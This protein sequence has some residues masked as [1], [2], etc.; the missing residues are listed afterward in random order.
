VGLNTELG[1]TPAERS[2]HLNS[3]Y[4]WGEGWPPPADAGNYSPALKVDQ[5]DYTS[6]V[7]S[8]SANEHGLYDLGGNTWEWCQDWYDA[9]HT[10]RTL[11]GASWV[12]A[13]PGSLRSAYRHG[14]LPQTRNF[15]HG[16]RIVLAFVPADPSRRTGG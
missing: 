1:A 14:S 12:D 2:L 8:F 11:R 7:G 5:Y 4:P 16:F 15:N 10:F 13:T 6:P 9:E 3:A